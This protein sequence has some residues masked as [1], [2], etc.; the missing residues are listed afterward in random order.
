ME[1]LTKIDVKF[2]KYF[3]KFIL[4]VINNNLYKMKTL[5]KNYNKLN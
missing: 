4:V 1:N 5:I 3:S 2:E